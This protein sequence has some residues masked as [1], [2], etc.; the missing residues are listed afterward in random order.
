MQASALERDHEMV[1]PEGYLQRLAAGLHDKLRVARYLPSSAAAVLDV[2]CADGALTLAMA[3]RYPAVRFVGIDL[4][5][6]FIAAATEHARRAALPNVEFRRVYLRELLAEPARFDCVVFASVLH[7]FWTYGEG[8]SSVLKALADAHELLRAGGTTIIRD[9]ILE[10]YA[11]AATLHVASMR[12]RV[13][14]STHA[15]ILHEFEA[16]WG[17][18]EH[19]AGI[20]HFLLKYRY[21]E[22]WARE[23]PE[24]YVPVTAER[25]LSIFALLGMQVQTHAR[26]LLP[27]LRERWLEDFGL[28]TEESDLLSSTTLIV[29][30][31]NQG[32]R[33]E[34]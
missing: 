30:Q 10:D 20:N 32:S 2:G 4:H 29:A 25:Y 3:A 16:Y 17:P 14:A 8:I 18:A 13:L 24:H 23:L 11:Q 7:E 28:H 21:Q 1:D 26:Y 15:A 27:F 9:M 31:K 34:R 33:R 12:A 6:D 19:L 5:A 22:N